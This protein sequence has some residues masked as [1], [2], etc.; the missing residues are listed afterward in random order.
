M[1]R[2]ADFLRTERFSLAKTAIEKQELAA[3]RGALL[4]YPE[5]N[6]ERLSVL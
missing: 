6:A 1:L 4:S 2:N 3:C 5:V